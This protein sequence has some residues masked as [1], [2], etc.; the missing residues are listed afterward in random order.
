MHKISRQKT[1][2]GT[3][4]PGIIRNGQYF[5]INLDVYEDGMINCWELVDLVGLK[6][7]L[8]EEWL[9]PS[10]PDGEAISI[11]GLGMYTI[12]AANW[13]Y[14]E[15]T[16]YEYIEKTIK[17]LNP[18][19]ENIYTLSAEEKELAKN[20]RITFSPKAK[21]FYV[22]NELFYETIDGDGLAVFMQHEGLNYL[23]N[24]VVYKDGRVTC[25]HSEFELNFALDELQEYFRKGTFFTGF[26]SPTEVIL[27]NF[28]EVLLSEVVY[29]EDIGEKYKELVDA[30][31]KLNGQKH[32]LKHAEKP[33]M[34][35]LRSLRATLEKS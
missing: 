16:Y 15:H 3:R 14:D 24:L 7:K 10:I 29:S 2:E 34:N 8:R 20:R 26:S 21:D 17:R 13:K 25:Y 31:C 4:I 27:D 19:L 9:V 12:E 35:I 5:F 22:K 28:A 30:H 1:I 23:V 11:H 18:K 32:H 6:E 33:I